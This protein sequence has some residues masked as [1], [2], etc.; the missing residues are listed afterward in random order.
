[1][2]SKTASL[3]LTHLFQP[4]RLPADGPPPLLLLLHGYGSNER[5]LIGLAPYLDSRFQIMSARAPHM[6]MPDGYAWFELGWTD[7]D[8]TINFQQAEQ[9]RAL[10]IGFLAQVL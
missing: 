7:T 10:L 9:S 2:T 6:L 3:S 5:D 1:M 8:I 4:P